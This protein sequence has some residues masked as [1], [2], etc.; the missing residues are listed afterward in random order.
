MPRK[1]PLL[2]DVRQAI[3]IRHYSTR[4]EKSYL[5]WV[6]QYILFHG[7]IHPANLAERDVAQYLSFLAQK[8]RVSASTQNQALNA[9]VFLYR[10]VL[11]RPL[12][13]I[14]GAVR[15]KRPERIPSILTPEEVKSVLG[16]LHGVH[17]IIG[18]LLYGSGLRLLE[19]LRLRVKDLDFH[20]KTITIREGKGAKDRVVTFPF[21]LHQPILNHLAQVKQT[22]EHDLALGYGEAKLPFA[23]DRKYP[24][25]G[26]QWGW[27]Y[28][29]P[30]T[31]RAV[32]PD[33][34]V[35]RRHY[36]HLTAIQ[37]Q[38]RLAARQCNITRPVGCH[39]L[40][41]SI[42]THLL[43]NGADIRTVQ[44]QLAPLENIAA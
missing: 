14:Q 42:A 36:I 21:M 44:D 10:N 32:D 33:S 34:D 37:R 3:R 2:E 22:H 41:H 39:T 25:A 23:L 1:S 13:N 11:F 31:R 5:Y 43:E 18:G 4:T 26:K 30:A 16:Q 27:Q 29:F 20:Y 6:R 35:I 12:G 19:C 24:N 40:R 17:W 9:L 15:A 7:K 8:R 38:I 28:V